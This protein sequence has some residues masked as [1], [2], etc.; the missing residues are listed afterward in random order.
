[1]A[2]ILKSSEQRHASPHKLYQFSEVE[3]EAENCLAEAKLIAE[4]IVAEA[5]AEAEAIRERTHQQALKDSQLTLEQQIARQVE[6]QVAS[7]S[8]ALQS[9]MREFQSLK[10][11]WP[12]HLEP[13]VCK[14]AAK[15]AECLIRKELASDPQLPLFVI[16][17]ALD[18]VSGASQIQLFLN[19]HD[20]QL[21]RESL[22]QVLL[23]MGCDRNVEVIA[24]QTISRGGCIV[25][26]AAGR[27]DQ[28]IESRLARI[29]EELG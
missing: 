26:T 4:E 22:Q 12:N 3:L 8:P 19:P 24:D 13:Q 9:V 20:H 23:E 11:D 21:L 2:T 10:E 27:I 5:E 14:L 28:Q 25:E 1:M 16:Q 18:L 29:L 7:V 17:E 6:E 15:M